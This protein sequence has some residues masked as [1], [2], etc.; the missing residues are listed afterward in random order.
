MAGPIFIQNDNLYRFAQDC[1]ER[2][3]SSI[4]VNRITKINPEEFF[5][6]EVGSI[7]IE[8]AYG[9][10]TLMQSGQEMWIDFYTEFFSFKAGY[11]RLLSKLN[12]FKPKNTK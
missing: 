9:P 3:G 6:V 8:G 5:E 2:Y 1:S 12:R 7:V 10:H 11:L 4:K